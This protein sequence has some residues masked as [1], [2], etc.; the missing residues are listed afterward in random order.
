MTMDTICLELSA[1]D[2]EQFD[3]AFHGF[4]DRHRDELANTFLKVEATERD[5]RATRIVTHDAAALRAVIRQLCGA[6]R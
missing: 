3:T 1:N 6:S 5:G 2:A 4:V